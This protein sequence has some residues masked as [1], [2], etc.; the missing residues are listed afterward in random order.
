M[1]TAFACKIISNKNP[2][3]SISIL[4]RQKQN[5]IK[6]VHTLKT[7][8]CTHTVAW[9]T[10]RWWISLLLFRTRVCVCLCIFVF[11]L[12]PIYTHRFVLCCSNFTWLKRLFVCLL[13]FVISFVCACRWGRRRCCSR[14]YFVGADVAVVFVV[15]HATMPHYTTTITTAIVTITITITVAATDAVATITSSNTKPIQFH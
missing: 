14:C 13:R 2:T 7:M 6:V 15:T 5:E 8:L 9:F 12:S 10:L 3:I 11:T 4:M 1:K